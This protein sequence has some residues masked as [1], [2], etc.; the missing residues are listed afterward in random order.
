MTELPLTRKSL[1]IELAKHSDVAW[2]EFLAIY[3]KAIVRYCLSRG[4]QEA[5]ALDA[6]QAVYAAIHQRI[7]TWDTDREKGSFRAW[8]FRVARNVSVDLLI[9]RSKSAARGDTLTSELLA[10]V[11]DHRQA[12]SPSQSEEES[13]A[14]QL[15]LKQALFEWASSQVQAEVR[16]VTWQAFCRTAI[17]G[18]KAE[19]VAEELGVPIGSVYTAK[20]RVMARIRDRVQDWQEAADQQLP[21]SADDIALDDNSSD[22]SL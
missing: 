19:V 5:D 21:E 10:Q 2:A 18:V 1:L 13:T 11:C 3:E 22:R 4:L 14:F 17:V 9:A 12:S 7:P 20:C 15:D 8:L 6:A 16:P